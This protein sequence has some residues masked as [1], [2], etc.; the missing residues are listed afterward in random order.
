MARSSVTFNHSPTWQHSG[1]SHHP[2]LLGSLWPSPI[3]SL[4]CPPCSSS[5]WV[6]QVPRS[7][8]F[9]TRQA[10]PVWAFLIS[11]R[12]QPPWAAVLPLHLPHKAPE[13]ISSTASCLGCSWYPGCWGH[14]ST[15]A[16]S[17]CPS[18]LWFVRREPRHCLQTWGSAFRSLSSPSLTLH[19]APTLPRKNEAVRKDPLLLPASFTLNMLTSTR[20]LLP[21]SLVCT[22]EGSLLLVESPVSLLN[23]ILF[24][25]LSVTSPILLLSQGY[26]RIL[27][28]EFLQSWET[29]LS[30]RCSSSFCWISFPHFSPKRL[31]NVAYTYFSFFLIA[32]SSDHSWKECPKAM[33]DFHLPTGYLPLLTPT[34]LLLGLHWLLTSSQSS[35]DF[36]DYTLSWFSS[37]LPFILSEKD[38]FDSCFVPGY[39]RDLEVRKTDT[40][41]VLMECT[42]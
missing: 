19:L 41:S 11:H 35:L 38:L 3:T 18:G 16:F 17:V 22:A 23:H 30:A 34:N 13:Q 7:L 26:F 24:S 28:G 21:F 27:P 20:I 15:M 6:P 5:S 29:H 32:Y 1:L 33:N 39:C 8:S 25:Y 10:A 2:E 9:P 40:T 4:S 42:I 37:W 31:K 14:S 36:C 12:R